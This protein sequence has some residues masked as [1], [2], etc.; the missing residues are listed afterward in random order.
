MLI[1]L[2][3]RLQGDFVQ[4]LVVMDTDQTVSVLAARLQAWGP[5]LFPPSSVPATTIRNEEGV[6]LQQSAT[7]TQAG[8][9]AG[10][11]FSVEWD[12]S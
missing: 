2:F 5:R 9:S 4:R 6:P 12:V 7:L 1:H 8:L 10:D 3:G 11:M